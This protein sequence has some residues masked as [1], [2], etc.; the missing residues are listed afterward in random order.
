[1][2]GVGKIMPERG[3]VCGICI[4]ISKID[5]KPTKLKLKVKANANILDFHKWLKNARKLNLENSF[6]KGGKI[7]E[8]ISVTFATNEKFHPPPETKRKQTNKQSRRQSS[9][10]G[11][12]MIE[13]SQSWILRYDVIK[14][15]P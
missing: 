7:Y 1:M 3:P 8:G 4:N 14:P 10:K 12:L 2:L 6:W 9:G 5:Q 13:Q 11:W 15:D